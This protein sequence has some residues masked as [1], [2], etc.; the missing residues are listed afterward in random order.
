MEFVHKDNHKT[1]NCE[2]CGANYCVNKDK[3]GECG[4]WHCMPADE[5]ESKGLCEF[6][7]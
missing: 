6:C 5:V 4:M 2:K 1:Y 7:R 3:N